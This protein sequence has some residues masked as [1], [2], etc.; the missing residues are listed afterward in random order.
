MFKWLTKVVGTANER[1]LKKLQPLVVKVNELE[2][3]T[4]KY[5]DA[6]LREKTAQFREKVAEG[7]S[8]DELLPSAFAVCR[9]AAW[10]VM[11]MRHYDVQLIG[12]MV[13]HQGKIAE[14]KTGEGKTLVAT[15]PV[16]LN[17]LSGKG[18]HV[19][20]VN[21]YLASR[22]AEWMG[23]VYRFLGLSVGT[24]VHG[25]SDAE[26]QANYGCDITYGTNNE[27]GFDYLRDNMKY[28]VDRR[29]QRGLNYAI[30]DEVDSILIDE[31][32]TPLIISGPAEK[33]SDW[34][35]RINA[36]IPFLKRE[37]DYLVDEKGHSVTLTELGV[38]KVEGRLKIDNLY[39][40][41][42]VEIL[43]HLHQAL[44]AHA[45]Y[46]RDEKYV[47]E[48]GKVVIVDE[49]TGR[50]MPGRR[51]SDGLHQAIEAKEGVAIE[52][53]N[54]TLATI[55]FQNYFRIY[56]KLAGM[57]GTAETEA[58]EFA[59]I[60]KLDTVVIPTNRPVARKDHNDL[61]YKTE[62]EKWRA[63]ADELLD[64]HGRGQPVLVG[65]TSVEKSE[66]LASLLKKREVPHSVLNAKFHEMEAAIVA[67]AGRLGAVTIATNMAGRGTDIMLGGNAEFMAKQATGE[68][69]GEAFEGAMKE[70]KEQCTAER[71]KVL[72][73]GGLHIIGTERHE[74]RRV[75]NQL[76]G[77]AGRQGDP[78]SS[79]FYLSLDDELMRL[80][81]AERI[82]KVMETLRM[83]DNEPIEHRWINSAVEKAQVKVE[84]RNFGIRKN[85]LEYDDVMN[86][87]RKAIYE[88]RDKVMMGED[89]HD[90]VVT[91]AE[92]VVYR[93]VDEHF[94]EG[95][96][97]EDF[98]PDGLKTALKAQF[99]VDVD[100]SGVD[101]PTFE[102]VQASAVE[103][104]K[105]FYEAREK[106][107]IEALKR[108]SEAHGH[109]NLIDTS[110]DRWRFFERERYLRA[111]DALW[112]HHLKVMESLKE[113][114]HLEAYGQK[115]PKQ[116][117]KKQGFA[118]FEMMMDKVKDNVC[119]VLFR[120]EG[121]SEEEIAEIRR[122]REEEEQRI[123]MSRQ[124]EAAAAAQQQQ[125]AAAAAEAQGRVVHQ[126]GTYTRAHQKIG[127]N[128]PCPCGSGQKFKKCHENKLDELD[129]LLAS[130]GQAAARM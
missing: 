74:S 84:A 105:S 18:V 6:Q 86:L 113:G 29:V 101:H 129:A 115:D 14:M 107:V 2:D 58:G 48:G 73:A 30:V 47:V 93:L 94:P 68:E 119:E 8:L 79:R 69:E 90:Q 75:D 50:K 54:E 111:I 59:E 38:D 45:L 52:Q 19:V 11:G 66:Y 72:E 80:F 109:V 97:A 25:L 92:D 28:S 37:E 108:A 83:P 76:R 124:G 98:D 32:R 60:Y 70:L 120:A 35:Y 44:K 88:L 42:N 51:W 55:T 4:R 123:I 64:A 24:I 91:A 39:D 95:V 10:R 85:V 1:T 27:F 20:T 61:I 65:T 46:K 116:E 43:H 122:R 5:T 33:S 31:A 15:L 118:L 22:D 96:P 82:R 102:N 78:G 9:E 114:I 56:N 89:I 99:N 100:F 121:P 13:L 17:A 40:A 103:Q 117:Y 7:T 23:R 87:Q 130:R 41:H 71:A 36:V 21:D 126:G 112:K 57:T 62:E 67:Q 12:G 125:Q 3:K 63:V 16:Y 26:R 104:V 110:A 81:G 127:R 49:F 53:E 106:K 34:Y 77:R 128:D